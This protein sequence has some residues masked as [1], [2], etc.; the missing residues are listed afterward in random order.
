[1]RAT[2]P[3]SEKLCGTATIDHLY[4]NGKRFVVWPMRV[5]YLRI[6]EAPTQILI[7]APKALFKHAV[8]R[9]Y[10]RRLMREAYRLNKHIL[11]ESGKQYQLAINYID[12]E[13]HDFSV[14]NKSMNKVI[15]RLADEV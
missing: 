1:M 14:I 13:K 9:N 12:K 10:L 7:W 4:Q 11:L 8:D 5:T 3:K 2:F 6:N 15:K